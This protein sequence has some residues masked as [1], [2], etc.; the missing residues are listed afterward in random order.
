VVRE[1]VSQHPDKSEIGHLD[2]VTEECSVEILAGGGEEHDVMGQN[3]E[4]ALVLS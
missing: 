4:S 1:G 2:G 3:P